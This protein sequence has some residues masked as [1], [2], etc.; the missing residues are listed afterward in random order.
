MLALF[1]DFY[2][3]AYLSKKPKKVKSDEDLEPKNTEESK[4]IQFLD[5][6]KDQ[7]QSDKKK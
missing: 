2:K 7:K 5:L 1:W 6:G 3:K 4:N